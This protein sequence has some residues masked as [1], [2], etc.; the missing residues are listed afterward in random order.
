MQKSFIRFPNKEK[1]E[2]MPKNMAR[3]A[4]IQLIERHLIFEKY[5]LAQTS[6]SIHNL[7]SEQSK[8]GGGN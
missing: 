3:T 4:N 7:L 1:A 8:E 5:L 6:L 2:L